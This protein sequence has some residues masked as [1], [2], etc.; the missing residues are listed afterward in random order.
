MLLVSAAAVLV[1]LVIIVINGL[2]KASSSAE[3]ITPPSSYAADITDGETMGSATAPVVIEIYSDFQCPYCARLVKE[4]LGRLVAD[5]VKPGMVRL[6]ARDIDILGRGTTGNE[7]VDLAVGAR[8]A[9]EQDR[10]WQ[11][12]DLAF[13]NQKVENTGQ[14]DA[15]FIARLAD[16]A[17]VDRAK[18][19]ACIQRDDV[20]QAV[21]KT[22]SDSRA[23]GV[24][25]TP[26]LR[27]NGQNVLGLQAY[28]QL[29]TAI[30]GLAAAAS[31]SAPAST[32]V[33]TAAPS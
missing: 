21:L 28:D 2:P 8:C 17:G 3:L 33:P 15:A 31:P 32:P 22:T 20:R 9:G 29:A 16:A 5:F 11:F 14:A 30:R 26:T 10:Y 25:S 13:W 23:L 4:Q 12:H 6:E 24:S 27:I 7:S 18:W 19:N 1:V